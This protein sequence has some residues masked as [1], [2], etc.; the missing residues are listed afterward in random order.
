MLREIGPLL[1]FAV[2]IASSELRGVPKKSSREM[3]KKPNDIVL[4]EK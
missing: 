2:Q 1:N 4:P 3:K